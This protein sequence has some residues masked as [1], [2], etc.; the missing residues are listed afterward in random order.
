MAISTRTYHDFTFTFS[1][2]PM[3]GDVS[4]SI[5]ATAVK[6]AMVAIMKTNYNERMFQ[7][8]FGSGIR[9]LLFEP[10][11]PITEER[12]KQEV[13]DCLSRH[14][15][16]ANVLGVTVE[17]QDEKNR[18]KVSILFSVSSEAEPQKLETFF[19]KV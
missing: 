19:E 11:N 9:A 3:S 1:A 6:R 10:M 12:I 4:K 7:P 14:E 17:G 15:P 2:N 8:E 13:I 5:G 16:R 18:Y